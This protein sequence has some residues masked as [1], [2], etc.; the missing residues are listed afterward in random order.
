MP[1]EHQ[2]RTSWRTYAAYCERIS[3]V[4]NLRQNARLRYA[5]LAFTERTDSYT[6]VSHTSR[7]HVKLFRFLLNNEQS[8]IPI[9]TILASEKLRKLQHT[10]EDDCI[11]GCCAM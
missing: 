7:K 4:N 8:R 5:R 9:E 10:P 6:A 1:Q 3:Y 11:L 2:G